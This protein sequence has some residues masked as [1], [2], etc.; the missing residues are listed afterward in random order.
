MQLD[1]RLPIGL[2]FSLFGLILSG[3][4]LVTWSNKMYE[5]SLGYNINLY[6]GLVLVVFGAIMLALTWRGRQKAGSSGK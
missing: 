4:G 3:Y 6:W 1:V 2:M 5:R